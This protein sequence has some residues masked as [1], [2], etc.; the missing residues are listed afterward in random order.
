MRQDPSNSRYIDGKPIAGYQPN[1]DRT[2]M[3]SNQSFT[4]S[5]GVGLFLDDGDSQSQSQYTA[6]TT[7]TPAPQ[8]GI[9]SLII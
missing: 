2:N 8:S 7:D 9:R 6:N 3:Q 5:R 4:L 1:I